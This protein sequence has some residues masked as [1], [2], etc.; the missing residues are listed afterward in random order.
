MSTYAAEQNLGLRKIV[1]VLLGIGVVSMLSL[2]V[3]G[4]MSLISLADRIHPVAGTVVFWGLCLAAGFFALYCL[5]A[6]AHL[7]PALV[8]SGRVE[9][10]LEMKLPDPAARTEILSG[11]IRNLPQELREMDVPRL[12]AATEG[13]TGADLK[14]MIEDG[15]AVYAYDKANGAKPHPLTEY[16]LQAIK[17]VQENKE[18]YATAEAQALTQPKSPL[19]G[20]MRSFVTTQMFSANQEDE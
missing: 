9:L 3:A 7:P 18:R 1:F 11:L 15:K 13:F 5:I 8:R 14:A 16:F 17:A 4:A 10:W 20:L 19:D 2:I 12:V 6:Y